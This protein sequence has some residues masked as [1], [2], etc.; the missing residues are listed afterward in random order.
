M[1]RHGPLSEGSRLTEF[2]F[3]TEPFAHQ[4]EEWEKHRETPARAIFWEMGTGKTKLLI[5]TAAWLA[6]QGK[7]DAMLVV[8]PNGVH[9]NWV[10]DELPRHM[11]D[12]IKY[13]AMT[14][15]A[16]KAGTK[17]HKEAREKLLKAEFPI[18]AIN[19]EAFITDRGKK[20]VWKFLKERKAFYVL[21][22]S[23]R[24]KSPGI[25]RTKSIVASGRYAEY[26][27]IA[28]GTPVANGPFD[29]FSPIRFLDEGYWKKHGL[30]TFSAFKAF[31]GMWETFRRRD[32][33]REFAKL[34]GYR[35]LDHL[36]ALLEPISTRLMKDDVL[37]LP[38]K[39]YT[40]Q[41]FQMTAE[42]ARLYR[43]LV[44]EYVAILESGEELTAP[45][46][47]TRELRLRQV[48]SGYLPSDEDETP[49]NIPGRNPRLALLIEVCEDIPH[50]AIIWAHFRKDIDQIC[51]ALGQEAVRYDGAVKEADR[52]IAKKRF[53][54]GNAKWFVG[55]PAA[56]GMG[57]TLVAAKTVIYYNNDYD[58]D[59]RLQSED[60]AH[61][62]GQDSPV[63]YIDLVCMDTIDVKIARAQQEKEK[64]SATI[65]GDSL[66]GRNFEGL[67]AQATN[68]GQDSSDA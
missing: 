60:R 58:L 4:R 12:S 66:R 47:I 51:E 34:L 32:T 14:Y 49:R 5:D 39:L 61:R 29:V 38:P 56:G 16:G 54:D 31:F 28:S 46:A 67:L 42:Q 64:I 2:Q 23:R 44:E 33:G 20:L 43:E 52:A 59:K 48:L 7:V 27:R 37:D 30:T 57:L 18:L 13:T 26:K 24:I 15:E 55:N 35:A 63:Q 11:P 50:Q 41:Y 19:Y 45:L 1:R 68:M 22:E 3:K 21:D 8:A 17:T 53:Q 25:K 36:N 10:E 65:L 62:I 9:R 40:M 6:L